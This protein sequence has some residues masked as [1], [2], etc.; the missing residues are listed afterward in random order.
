MTRLSFVIV[1][2]PPEY[3]RVVLVSG[4][5]DLVIALQKARTARRSTVLMAFPLSAS[6]ALL[7]SAERFVSLDI[8][9][10]SRF[11]QTSPPPE[12]A[13]N[14]TELYFVGGRRLDPYPIIR[15]LFQ[16]ARQSVVVVDAYLDEQI[17]LTI[18]L[19]SRSVAIELPTNRVPPDFCSMVKMQRADGYEIDVHHTKAFPDRFLKVD[20][21]LWHSGHSFKD[22]GNKDSRFSQVMDKEVYTEFNRRLGQAL[23]AAKILCA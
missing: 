5:S 14:Q 10:D 19:L 12:S 20:D 21:Q 16:R 11:R 6:N 9:L 7:A 8:V 17:L 23:A 4:D 22:L 13:A 15:Q 2:L 3:D 1:G 18:Q